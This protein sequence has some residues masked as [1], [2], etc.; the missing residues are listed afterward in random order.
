MRYKGFWTPIMVVL[1]IFIVVM[2]LIIIQEAGL[3]N[4]VDWS[5]INPQIIQF[6]PWIILIGVAFTIFLYLRN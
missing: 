4:A 6:A 5:T 2:F 3:F 1:G